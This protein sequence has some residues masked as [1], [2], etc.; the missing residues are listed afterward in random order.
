IATMLFYSYGGG[1]YGKVDVLRGF[2]F[3]ALICVFQII[4]S[5]AWLHRFRFGPMEWLWRWWTYRGQV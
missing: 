3:I 4:G 2:L 5:H 1:L